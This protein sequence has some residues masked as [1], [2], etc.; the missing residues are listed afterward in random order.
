MFETIFRPAF[1]I[2]FTCRKHPRWFWT[3]VLCVFVS[4]TFGPFLLDGSG[5]TPVCGEQFHG[6]LTQCPFEVFPGPTRAVA[7]SSASVTDPPGVE[8]A[9]ADTAG[10]HDTAL[11]LATLDPQRE[12]MS[13]T[14]SVA[15][16]DQA[17][18]FVVFW[19]PQVPASLHRAEHDALMATITKV[20]TGLLI[21]PLTR[22][23][24]SSSPAEA[25][26]LLVPSYTL[27]T[28]FVWSIAVSANST[29]TVTEIFK[30]GCSQTAGHVAPHPADGK[31]T[32]QVT[33]W[34]IVGVNYAE[35]SRLDHH[36]VLL[37]IERLPAHLHSGHVSA[38]LYVPQAIA[39]IL[40]TG[41]SKLCVCLV[42]SFTCQ[43]CAQAS[44]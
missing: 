11:R 31:D 29:V 17:Y 44:S 40:L 2:S 22:P 25:P 3:A 39:A 18:V 19:G 4:L 20:S 9:S 38:W 14:T 43:M 28:Q 26:V 34:V 23:L 42:A 7:S 33:V 32:S 21:F 35:F 8:M 27:V 10:C 24:Y 15:Q 6:Q 41:Q 5:D 16:F 1:K 30:P 36:A 12:A 37:T 13:R